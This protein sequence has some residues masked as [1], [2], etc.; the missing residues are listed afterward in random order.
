VTHL[1]NVFDLLRNAHWYPAELPHPELRLMK[2]IGEK[3][4]EL[5]FSKFN[6]IS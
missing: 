4:E 6:S 1:K 3:F 5:F 2:H